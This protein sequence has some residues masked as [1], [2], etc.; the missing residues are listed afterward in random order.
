VATKG[1]HHSLDEVKKLVAAGAFTVMKGRGLALLV[2][3][4][5][6]R[7]AM[8]FIAAALQML[9]ADNFCETVQL[10]YD[11]AD[12]YGIN[13]QSTGWYVKLCID[14]DTPEVAVISFHPPEHPMRTPAGVVKPP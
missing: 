8:G 13:I 11:T 2:P 9:T 5:T 7:E 6:Y 4:L 10:T 14:H 1:P 3:P 12:V